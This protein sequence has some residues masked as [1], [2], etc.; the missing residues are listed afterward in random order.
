[1]RERDA[2]DAHEHVGRAIGQLGVVQLWE[3]R[4]IGHDLLLFLEVG[5]AIAAPAARHR[6]RR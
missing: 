3:L 1:V 5:A 6:R 4:G 2:Q